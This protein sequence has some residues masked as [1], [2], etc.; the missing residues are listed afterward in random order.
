MTP[1]GAVTAGA[2]RAATER[3]A[4]SRDIPT[5]ADTVRREPG[6][7]MIDPVCSVARLT[8]RVPWLCVPPSRRVCRF[9]DSEDSRRPHSQEQWSVPTERWFHPRR[10]VHLG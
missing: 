6:C 3:A 9:A 4:V 10:A 1:A 5:G 7:G 8:S 2:T